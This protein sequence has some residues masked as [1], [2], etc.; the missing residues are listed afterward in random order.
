M[1][2]PKR[3]LLCLA[4]FCP[5]QVWWAGE[6]KQFRIIPIAFDGSKD[7]HTVVRHDFVRAVPARYVRINPIAWHG[8]ISLRWELYEVP[9]KPKN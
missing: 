4:S 3:S 2:I 5:L 6:D 7:Q 8:H 1:P 9:V